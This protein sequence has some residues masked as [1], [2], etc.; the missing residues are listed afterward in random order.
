MRPK[1]F[2]AS[3]TL[4]VFTWDGWPRNTRKPSST[5]APKRK[6][7]GRSIG[8]ESP[9]GL[10]DSLSVYAVPVLPRTYVSSRAKG[11][12]LVS[13]RQPHLG[14]GFSLPM[15]RPRQPMTIGHD[16][17]KT[18]ATC[19]SSFIP[20]RADA[21]YCSDGC[22][23]KAY[24]SRSLLFVTPKICEQQKCASKLKETKWFEGNS[25]HASNVIS[26][27]RTTA[28]DTPSVS[29]WHRTGQRSAGVGLPK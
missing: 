18:C 6:D 1:S 16:H 11:Q 15:K 3:T 5:T 24:R 17:D 26:T 19:G 9:D 29:H 28:R 10:T 12:N 20:R 25:Q 14:S 13:V 7:Y 8:H 4:V 21:Q 2:L 27:Q 23:Q 22:R